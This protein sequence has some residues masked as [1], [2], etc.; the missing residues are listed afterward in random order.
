VILAGL[1][2]EGGSYRTPPEKVLQEVTL[3]RPLQ[4]R[5]VLFLSNE[6]DGFF[7]QNPFL[8]H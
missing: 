6:Q 2:R 8:S 7:D 4:R 3:P 5:G 1:I